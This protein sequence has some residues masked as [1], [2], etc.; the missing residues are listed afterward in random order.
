[1]SEPQKGKHNA[2]PTNS[3]GLDSS[4]RS[5][6]AGQQ[7]HPNGGKHQIDPQ[8][9]GSHLRGSLAT[10]CFWAISFV[11]S[12]SRRVIERVARDTI[13]GLKKNRL[14]NAYRKKEQLCL[15]LY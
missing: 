11:L 5:L 3:L 8:C 7:L 6:M 2:S 13:A 15:E 14:K 1:M 4:W 9:R 10:E 12:Y